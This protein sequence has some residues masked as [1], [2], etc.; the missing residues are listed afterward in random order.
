MDQYQ[1][2]VSIFWK[3]NEQFFQRTIEFVT[4]IDLSGN[5]LSDGIPEELTHL[6]GLRFFNLSRNNLSGSI[7][8]KI[9]VLK[10]LESLDLSLNELSGVIPQ[11]ISDLSSLSTLNLSSN[12]LWSRIPTGSQ[13]QTLVDP[14]IYS[15]NVG[16]CGCPLNIKCSEG[17]W[18][19]P[20]SQNREELAGL[21]YSVI[22]GIV[23]GYWLWF[24][25]LIFLGSWRFSFFRFIDRSGTKPM[26]KILYISC[27]EK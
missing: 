9:G 23:F 12:R 16:L 19:A 24:G 15:N 25:A 10:L 2:R 21:F 20:M 11:S 22:L 17:S 8:E 26:Q 5:S 27:T 7:P 6:H 13:L 1:D 14:S 18:S 4:G 3:G